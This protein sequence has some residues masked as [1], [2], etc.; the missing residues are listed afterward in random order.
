MNAHRT[1]HERTAVLRY[2]ARKSPWGEL[3]VWMLVRASL[4]RMFVRVRVCNAG[5]DPRAT[6]LPL[7]VIANHPTW[8]DGYV[9]LLLSRHFGARRFLMMDAAQLRRYGFFAWLG[10]F[11]VERS[12]ARDVTR[13]LAY[14]ANLLRIHKPVWVWLFPQAE[15]TPASA[16]PVA[17]HGGV[18]HIL[19]RA[20]AGDRTIGVL[21]V[22]WEYVFRGEQHPE[23]VVRLGEVR[24]FD[25]AGARDVA[26]VTACLSAALTSV[27][28]DV[29]RDVAK[30][31]FAA[32]R[33][34]FRG[35]SGVNDRFDRLLGRKRL[36]ADE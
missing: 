10:C 3:L 6:G 1:K 12:D 33:T 24:R 29:A 25:A 30:D 19:R 21:P 23:V 13:S 11:G 8:W 7:L 27:M 5:D 28:D 2:P 26:R 4:R 31:D 15:I 32:Y 35:R 18:A 20:T 36:V 9:A 17:L 22:A 16:R 14:A 34:I